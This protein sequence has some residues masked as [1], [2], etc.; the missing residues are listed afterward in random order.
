MYRYLVEVSRLSDIELA[1]SL[2]DSIFLSLP[3]K[4]FPFSKTRNYS[5]STS[6]DFSHLRKLFPRYCHNK[7][8]FKEIYTLKKKKIKAVKFD[9]AEIPI[10]IF[11]I[12][13]FLK[14][15]S[16]IYCIDRHFQIT[17]DLLRV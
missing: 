9:V 1:Q 2:Y 15:F 6:K 11:L 7:L 17:I 16:G 14:C 5:I 4:F 10:C 13:F 3:H 8:H 12:L